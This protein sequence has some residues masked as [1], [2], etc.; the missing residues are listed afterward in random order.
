[1]QMQNISPV[2]LHSGQYEIGDICN[3]HPFENPG[4]MKVQ[5]DMETDKGG[6]IVIQRRVPNG[7]V[8]FY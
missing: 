2:L 1:M 8:N 7:T 3:V 6:W 4:K 5:C